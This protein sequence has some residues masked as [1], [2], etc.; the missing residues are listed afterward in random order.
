M[1]EKLKLWLPVAIWYGVIFWLSSIPQLEVTSEPIG[2]FL[3]RK[4]AHLAEYAILAFLILKAQRYE[5]PLL[6]ITLAAILGIADEFHQGFVPTRAPKVVDLFFDF[7]G[8]IIGVTLWKYL[9][10]LRKKLLP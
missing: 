8:A 3:T 5:K 6:A 4:F 9:P 10:T 7:G 2:N 1:D